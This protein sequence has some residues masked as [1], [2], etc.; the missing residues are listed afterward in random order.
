MEL[1]AEFKKG[2]IVFSKSVFPFYPQAKIEVR[3]CNAL[4]IFVIFCFKKRGMAIGC[5]YLGNF[6]IPNMYPT[7]KKSCAQ[8][9]IEGKSPSKNPISLQS[10]L[11]SKSIEERLNGLFPGSRSCCSPAW[12]FKARIRKM[13]VLR[14]TRI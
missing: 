12:Q 3:S 2:G 6:A 7:V 11:Q 10:P 14:N 4:V 5:L 8:G 9:R 13:V 1:I